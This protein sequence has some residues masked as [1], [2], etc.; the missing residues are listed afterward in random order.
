VQDHG[1][2]P[3]AMNPGYYSGRYKDHHVS[4]EGSL[5]RER[6]GKDI[7][8]NGGEFKGVFRC[9]TAQRPND[10]PPHLLYPSYGYNSDGLVGHPQDSPL[11]LGGKGTEN[12]FAPPISESEVVNPSQML[13]VGDAFIGW[14]GVIE[15]GKVRIARLFSARDFLDSTRRASLRH[16]GRANV[17]FCDG[18][19]SG[20]S[21]EFLFSDVSDGALRIWNRD[22]KPHQERM[23]Q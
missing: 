23:K 20:L 9:P 4:W 12:G 13:G 21:L 7:A 1:A 3:L 18:H 22:N 11:G 14:N 5:F 17:V 19:A 2:Y 6:L 8:S 10:F 15:D 16:R